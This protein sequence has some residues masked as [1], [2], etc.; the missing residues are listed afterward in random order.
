MEL[1]EGK[2]RAMWEWVDNVAAADVVICGTSSA[3]DRPITEAR[4]IDD[5]G[6]LC[7]IYLTEPTTPVFPARLR[8][9]H[10]LRLG[11]LVRA[12]NA[13]QVLIETRATSA[14][15]EPEGD[16]VRYA[17]LYAALMSAFK[18]RKPGLFAVRV[19][20][21][22]SIYILP[23]H[24]QFLS[25][26]SDDTMRAMLTQISSTVSITRVTDELELC[27]LLQRSAEPAHKLV[28]LAAI[29]M[30]AA[31]QAPYIDPKKLYQLK[32]LP[33]FD[34]VMHREADLRMADTLMQTSMTA[35]G[36]ALLSGASISGA[37][38]FLMACYAA[39]MLTVEQTSDEPDSAPLQGGAWEPSS[40]DMHPTGP[41]TTPGP[42]KPPREPLIIRLREPREH[43]TT[44]PIT[45]PTTTPTAH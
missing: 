33:K 24:R 37:R 14:A 43:S 12:L 32:R 11:E 36:V 6:P 31:Q 35:R 40:P 5:G 13:S 29:T 9:H 26:A 2:T 18:A 25:V 4:L 7:P 45:T 20:A 28:W 22:E 39:G 38:T 34:G 16:A 42:L 10:P 1:V 3:A 17:S 21:W 8:M 15:H 27:E 23:Q 44:M 41:L 19:N 30:P